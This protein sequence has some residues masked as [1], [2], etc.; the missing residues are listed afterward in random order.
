M[1]R[2]AVWLTALALF[3]SVLPLHSGLEQHD[4]LGA[5]TRVFLTH[6][7]PGPARHLESSSEIELP[8]CPACTLKIQTIST[9]VPAPSSAAGLLALGVAPQQPEMLLTQAPRALA[10]SR[11]P[12][13]A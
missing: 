6:C 3:V 11:G 1:R 10:F 4:A 12:P 8:R 13:Q 2:L 7:K 9:T 5:A